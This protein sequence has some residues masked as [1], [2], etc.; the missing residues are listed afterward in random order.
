MPEFTYEIPNEERYLQALLIKLGEIGRDDLAY[1]LSWCKCS[2]TKTTNFSKLRWDGYYTIIDF[3]VPLDIYSRFVAGISEDDKKCISNIC[4]EVMPPKNG[5]DAMEINF[6]ISLDEE[7]RKDDALTELAKATSEFSARIKN[8]ILPEDIKQKAKEMS[9]VYLYTYCVENALRAFITKAAE[10]KLGS[11][12]LDRLLLSK[13][14][15]SKIEKR[16]NQEAKKK[17]LSTR[18]NS[19]VF[20]LDIDDLGNLIQNNWEIFSQYFESAQW[21]TTNVNEVAACR[22]IIAHHG[23]LQKDERDIIRTDFLK[24]LRQIS[25]TFK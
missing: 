3:E 20:Y 14:M 9:E 13:D 6:K 12:F 11:E 8:E 22:N 23:Y 25:D 10:E 5:L 17:W 4:N 21:I 15:K 19:D 24:I 1:Q 18:G 7:S 16:K 2:I